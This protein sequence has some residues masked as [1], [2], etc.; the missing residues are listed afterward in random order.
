MLPSMKRTGQTVLIAH[1]SAALLLAAGMLSLSAAPLTNTSAAKTTIPYV[2]TRHDIVKDL[3]WL[4]EVGTNDIV[5][6]LG[7]GDG[8]VVIAAVRDFGARKAVGIELDAQLVQQSRE[9]AAP[10][11]V[12]GRV[13]FI[14]G[15]LFTN[16]FSLA[17]VV[18]LYLGQRANLDLRAQ[19]VR[20]LK[21]GARVVSHQF[22]MGEWTADKTLDVRTVLLGMYGER[23]NE[24]KD[25][26]DVPDFDS[27]PGR[28]NHDMLSVWNVPA[29][30]AGVWRGSVRTASGDRELRLTLHQ[31]LAEVRGSF[32]LQGP[33]N[34]EGHVEADLWGEHLRLHCLPA[35][36]PYGEH[37][38]WFDG[39]ARGD[40][41]NGCLWIAQRDGTQEVQW[42]GHRDKADF[43]GTWE[44]PGPSN[45]PV[46]LK[47][48]RRDGR[49]AATY[50]DKNRTVPVWAG[51]NKPIPVAD[52]Y[53]FGGGFYFT[54]L[55]GLQ[56]TRLSGGSRITGPENGWLIGE[57][58]A[59]E[60]TLR[61][62]I[63]FYPY[64]AESPLQ[65][66]DRKPPPQGRRDWQP[67]R[68]GP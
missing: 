45:S 57:A 35:G 41:L 13:E 5:Y 66:L 54:L 28:A 53:D 68:V 36:G 6:D 65:P 20:T 22:G 30:V 23:H 38:I 63:A 2:P 15:D 42:T 17:S 27:T 59:Q 49:L 40:T 24:F 44:W 39:H 33:T 11:G 52:F 8:R 34:V 50:E 55:L 3:L 58:V 29:P 31:R 61:G 62:T 56:G 9:K 37:L 43:T 46:Q 51:G 14:H 4:A 7:A 67:R 47:I 19:I 21:P 1:V 25:N 48:E 18:V 60:N 10:A 26:P 16:D 64:A 12:S 32:Q